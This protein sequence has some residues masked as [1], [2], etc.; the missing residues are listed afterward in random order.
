MLELVEERW[1]VLGT[2]GR[3][4]TCAIYCVHGP[5]LEVRVGYSADDFHMTRRV[6]DLR[7]ARRLAD[8][9]RHAALATGVSELTL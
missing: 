2:S 3:V 5:G 1:R 4:I 7:T 9:W 8:G 6:A